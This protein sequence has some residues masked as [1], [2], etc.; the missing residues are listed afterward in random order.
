MPSPTALP[1]PINQLDMQ[2]MGKQG[3]LLSTEL[4]P[5]SA[6]LQHVCICN[7]Q[8]ALEGTYHI[9]MKVKE[10]G[11]SKSQFESCCPKK[12]AKDGRLLLPVSGMLFST[13]GTYMVS[14]Q[15]TQAGME[16]GASAHSGS[17]VVMVR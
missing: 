6:V 11:P 10:M 4:P 16:G 14:V 5:A 1:V 17:L 8:D 15:I 13:P 12:A 9:R 7:R 3:Q 2:L